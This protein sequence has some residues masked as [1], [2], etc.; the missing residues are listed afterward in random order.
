MRMV[1][2]NDAV[3][4]TCVC[5]RVCSALH[6]VWTALKPTSVRGSAV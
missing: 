6:P 5:A 3:H 1:E 4:T 2:N